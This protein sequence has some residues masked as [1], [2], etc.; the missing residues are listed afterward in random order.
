MLIQGRCPLQT[1]EKEVFPEQKAQH[2][3]TARSMIDDDG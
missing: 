1:L 2:T 3:I